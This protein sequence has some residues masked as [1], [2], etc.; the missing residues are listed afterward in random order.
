MDDRAKIRD[1]CH[2]LNT[3][4][5]EHEIAVVSFTE[6]DYLQAF[7]DFYEISED[8]DLELVSSDEGLYRGLE[9][10]AGEESGDAVA[11]ETERMFG[12]P[13]AVT[14]IRDAEEL[15][16]ELEGVDGLAPFFFVFDI[17]FCEYDGFTLCFI[18]GTNN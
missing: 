18:C 9:D 13:S 4:A 17:L 12:L 15:L 1:L 3:F 7:R 14:F 2:E 8:L 6:E 5:M 10:L 11:A 16:E